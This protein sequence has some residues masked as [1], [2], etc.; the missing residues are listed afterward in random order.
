MD[1][2]QKISK[3]MDMN[4][5]MLSVNTALGKYRVHILGVID[6]FQYCMSLLPERATKENFVEVVNKELHGRRKRVLL[7]WDRDSVWVIG[8]A[9]CS[10][11]GKYMKGYD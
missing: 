5:F 8:L 4:T 6:K 10:S 11:T 9:N 3:N 7:A 1:D 2:I